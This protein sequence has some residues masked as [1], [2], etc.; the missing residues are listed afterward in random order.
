MTFEF[1]AAENQARIQAGPELDML[2]T[3]TTTGRIE[4]FAA[5]PKISRLSRLSSLAAETAPDT[6]SVTEGVLTGEAPTRFEVDASQ[7]QPLGMMSPQ[8]D[9]RSGHGLGLRASADGGSAIGE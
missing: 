1:E 5:D 2:R 4:H 8:C 3:Q 7:N 9:H 6:P